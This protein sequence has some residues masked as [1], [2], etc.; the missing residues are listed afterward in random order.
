MN[1][2][3][4]YLTFAKYALLCFGGGY[5]LVP[6]LTAD[7]VGPGKVMTAEEFGN[8]VSIAQSTPGPIAINT[9]TYVGYTQLGLAGATAATLGIVTPALFLVLTAMRLL[10]RYGESLPVQGFLTGMRPASFGMILAAG[11]IFA[12]LSVFTG[13]IP[14]TNLFSIGIRPMALVIAVAT[15]VI[16]L[17]KQRISFLWLILGS[18]LLG[19]FFC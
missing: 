1:L 19:A 17:K 15:V 11:V 14:W 3:Q 12:E 2:T 5:L 16:L 10:K 9:A 4:L 7:L 18:A 6:L 13:P 8:L